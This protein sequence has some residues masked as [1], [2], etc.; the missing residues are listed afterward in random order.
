MVIVDSFAK[1]VFARPCKT[2]GSQEV[3]DH[4]SDLFSLF[5]TPKR[6]ISDRGKAFTS[7]KFK[8]FAT[9][10]QV[11]HILNAVASPRSNGQVER[12]NRTI[13]DGLNTSIDNENE[14]QKSLPNVIWGINNTINKSTGFSPHLLMFGYNK[15]RHAN[16]G[17]DEFDVGGNIR[18]KAIANMDNQARK[19]KN[20]FDSKRKPSNSYV[21]GE[22]VL[23]SGSDKSGK[24]VS[25][26]I[27]NSKFGGPYKINKVLGNDRYEIVAIEGM[28][29]Y[30]RFKA[31]VAVETLRKFEGG[32]VEETDSDSSINSTDELIELLEG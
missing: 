16:I 22:L 31:T 2:V 9:K 20:I 27:G 11:K 32:I 19:M 12:Y 28:K 30:K 5:G 6:I 18:E 14:W 21:I 23:W 29:G 4:L 24:E 17:E 15:N 10:Y 8:S 26:K 13:L 1:F 3:I 25:R 7:T